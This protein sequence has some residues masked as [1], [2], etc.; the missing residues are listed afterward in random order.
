MTRPIDWGKIKPLKGR[1]KR[2]EC[3]VKGCP[4]MTTARYCR[5]HVAELKRQTTVPEGTPS[6]RELRNA[7]QERLRGN[8]NE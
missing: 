3:A 5:Y 6:I 7:N 1:P 8:S 4:N 2:H